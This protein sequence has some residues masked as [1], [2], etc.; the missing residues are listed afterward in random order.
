MGLWGKAVIE[1]KVRNAF[2]GENYFHKSIVVRNNEFKDNVRQLLLAAN[3]KRVEFT[4]NRVTNTVKENEYI[5]CG[6]V[7]TD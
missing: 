6:E 5:N 3:V 1:T 4:S 7:I 2:D